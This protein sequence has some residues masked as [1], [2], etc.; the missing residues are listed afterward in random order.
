MRITTPMTDPTTAAVLF[1][2]AVVFSVVSLVELVSYACSLD[3]TNKIS[4]EYWYLIT[5]YWPKYKCS[6]QI[7]NQKLL[8]KINFF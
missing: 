6:D 1:E 5:F 8:I 7:K 4:R 3:S 2:Q